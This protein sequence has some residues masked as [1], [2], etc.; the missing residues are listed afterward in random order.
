MQGPVGSVLPPP[1]D[2]EKSKDGHIA[3]DAISHSSGHESENSEN[4]QDGVE[5]VRA[6]TAI[7]TKPTL[8]SMFV[9]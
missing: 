8:I 6:I 9:L 2:V 3:S 5:R 7:W 4:F 1:Q